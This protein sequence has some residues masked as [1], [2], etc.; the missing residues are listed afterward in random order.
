MSN[1]VYNTNIYDNYNNIVSMK[2]LQVVSKVEEHI[3]DVEKDYIQLYEIV[4]SQKKNE[5]LIE[6]IKMKEKDIFIKVNNNLG[7]ENILSL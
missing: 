5:E 3:L 6:W 2:I 4:L 1:I 7:C